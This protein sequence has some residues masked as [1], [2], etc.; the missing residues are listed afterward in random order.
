MK[1]KYILLGFALI[2]L[3]ANTF[4]AAD[5]TGR[6][7]VGVGYTML[8]FS[9]EGGPDFD[10]S[11]LGVRAGY[12]YNK[13]FS[14]EGRLALGVGDD[15]QYVS[16]LATDVTVELG[17]ML[18]IYAVGHIPLSETFKLYGLVGYSDGE[19]KF[20]AAGFSDTSESDSDLSFGL[21]AEFYMTPSASVGIEYTSYISESDYD[22][23]GLGI[24]L[25]YTF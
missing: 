18:G 10:L 6:G 9:P 8:S 22:I 2:G 7:Y 21:G 11:A 5:N 25:N 24:T 19:L 16:V 23:D 3:S 20:K 1:V 17:S 14:L 15:T 12:F 13:Y 4:A